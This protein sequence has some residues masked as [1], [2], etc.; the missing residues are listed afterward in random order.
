M[1]KTLKRWQ[2]FSKNPGSLDCESDILSLGYRALINT[3]QIVRNTDH[4]ISYT[5]MLFGER[6]IGKALIPIGDG[7]RMIV[8]ECQ[9]EKARGV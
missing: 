7:G 6:E 3:K 8:K 4:D 1:H 5:C 2:S 9:A